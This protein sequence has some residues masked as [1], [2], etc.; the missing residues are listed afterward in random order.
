[1]GQGVSDLVKQGRFQCNG[2]RR[3]GH[4]GQL[5]QL[6]AQVIVAQDALVSKH[7]IQCMDNGEWGRAAITGA[8]KIDRCETS[9]DGEIVAEFLRAQVGA[10]NQARCGMQPDSSEAV[11]VQ[12]DLLSFGGK[13]CPNG[14]K[15]LVALFNP[16]GPSQTASFGYCFPVVRH[17]KSW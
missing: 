8:G 16:Q 17:G 10:F 12:S 7:A 11:A 2:S 3:K 13:S 4:P 14:G 6:I 9:T 15:L 5:G 1:M